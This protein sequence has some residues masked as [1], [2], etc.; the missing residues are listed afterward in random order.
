MLWITQKPTKYKQDFIKKR[1]SGDQFKKKEE[2]KE[3]KTNRRCFFVVVFFPIKTK[4][5]TVT[6]YQ[7]LW[8]KKTIY[9][10]ETLVNMQTNHQNDS[11]AICTKCVSV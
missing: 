8:H 10:L 7:K 4:Q 11:S 9:R 2:E 5:K 1:N 3:V 6:E